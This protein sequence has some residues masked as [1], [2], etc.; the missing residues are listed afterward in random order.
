MPEANDSLPWRG[1]GQTEG[2]RAK[3]QSA[4][5]MGTARKPHI[6]AR[7]R[8]HFMNSSKL[9]RADFQHLSPVTSLGDHP[10]MEEAKA[11][12]EL[13]WRSYRKRIK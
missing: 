11:A 9:F 1:T 6:G 12:C 7:Y 8:A 13:H 2:Y 3:Y 4:W 10:T 5:P